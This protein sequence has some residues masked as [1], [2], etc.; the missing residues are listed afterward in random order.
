MFLGAESSQRHRFK[1]PDV[2]GI[3]ACSFSL[4]F[5]GELGIALSN[6]SREVSFVG[7]FLR[8]EVIFEFRNGIAT[9]Q[10]ALALGQLKKF[11]SE[12]LKSRRSPGRMQPF[13]NYELN[14]IALNDFRNVS[15]RFFEFLPGTTGL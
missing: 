1:D 8:Q 12:G 14:P 9:D 5:G 11:Q 15:E 13:Y 2:I 6:L 7:A 10:K 3:F 4:K